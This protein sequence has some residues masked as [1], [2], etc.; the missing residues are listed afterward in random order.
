LALAKRFRLPGA[1]LS[2][3]PVLQS[4]GGSVGGWV[5]LRTN[6]LAWVISFSAVPDG[7]HDLWRLTT[8]TM[9][10]R[11]G[12]LS[13]AQLKPASDLLRL[14]EQG[15]GKGDILSLR[16]TLTDPLFCVLFAMPNP[17]V[18]VNRDYFTT[19]LHGLVVHGMK[20]SSLSIT[21]SAGAGRV[22]T[23]IGS[24]EADSSFMGLMRLGTTATL[25]NDS[26]IWKLLTLNVSPQSPSE[27]E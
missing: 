23:A 3:P 1:K 16:E 9:V 5:E 27:K 13:E 19:L 7:P 18:L 26:G 22:V 8:L 20:K 6:D 10:P 11:G 25:I 12:A 4:A 15:V 17:Q 21:H 24:W 14:W 2:A